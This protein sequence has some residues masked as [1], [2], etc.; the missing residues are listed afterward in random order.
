MCSVQSAEL[1]TVVPA[2]KGKQ[3]GSVTRMGRQ[4]EVKK[5]RQLNTPACIQ[6]PCVS[7][8]WVR[9]AC[10][11]TSGEAEREDLEFK[12]TLGVVVLNYNLAGSSQRHF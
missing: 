4:R 10:H 1:E 12:V 11:P 6:T 2:G 5:L 7:K 9:E 8:A 3:R